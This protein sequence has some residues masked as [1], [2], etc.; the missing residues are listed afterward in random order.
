MNNYEIPFPCRRMAPRGPE[1]EPQIRETFRARGMVVADI[2]PTSAPFFTYV[3]TECGRLYLY[4]GSH[5]GGQ[6]FTLT[7]PIH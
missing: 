5:G 1:Y 7:H 4:D 3:L 2:D 6:R